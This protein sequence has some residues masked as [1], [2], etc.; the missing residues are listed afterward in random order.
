MSC[1]ACATIS[2]EADR[3]PFWDGFTYAFASGSRVM[4]PD[5]GRVLLTICEACSVA[6]LAAADKRFR[7]LNRENV[8]ASS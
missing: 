6:S 8:E 7:I 3:G 5:T 2:S 1:P 4:H